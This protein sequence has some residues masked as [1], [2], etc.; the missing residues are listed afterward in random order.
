MKVLVIGGGISGIAISHYLQRAGIGTTLVEAG[1]RLGG[2]LG[3]GSLGERAI[4]FGGKNIGTRYTEFRKFCHGLGVDDFEYFG[5]NTSR[6]ENGTLVSIDRKQPLRTLYNMVSTSRPRDLWRFARLARRVK[7]FPDDGFADSPFFREAAEALGGPVL[8]EVFGE[9]ICQQ[10]IRPMVVRMNGAEADEIYL[11]SFGS[12]LRVLLDSYDQLTSGMEGLIAKFAARSDILLNASVRSLRVEKR[13]VCG[14]RVEHGD[15]GRQ[16][17]LSVDAVCVA[18]PAPT[19]AQL[20]RPC[21]GALAALLCKVRYFPM[22]VIVAQYSREIFSPA[23]RAVVFGENS[24]VSNAGAYGATDLGTV[25]YTFSGRRARH[26]IAE[27]ATDDRL[28]ALAEDNLNGHIA[29]SSK[30][31]VHIAS[32]RFDPGLCAF[33]TDTRSLNDKIDSQEELGGIFFTGDYRKGASIEA[34]FVAAKQC[35]EKVARIA[36]ASAA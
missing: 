15:G 2:R 13:R 34:C 30:E 36:M 7:Q 9:R 28:L 29:V 1:P 6:V 31:R 23:I 14:V 26:L 18:L 20:V 27:G 12:N 16:Q 24:V 33:S 11:S 25:R 4:S 8:A 5:I 35:A 10:L 21:A 17:E 3:F 22:H 19:A 32:R